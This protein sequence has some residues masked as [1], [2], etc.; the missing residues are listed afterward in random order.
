MKR[1]VLNM[2]VGVVAGCVAG[3]VAALL[4]TQSPEQAAT[5]RAVPVLPVVSVPVVS[6]RLTDL[7]EVLCV[8]TPELPVG[9]LW[10]CR[11]PDGMA[12]AEGE[13]LPAV[14]DGEPVSAKAVRTVLDEETG[15]PSL[16]LE[17]PRGLDST[18]SLE[19]TVVIADTEQA[20]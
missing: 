4:F 14:A 11:L 20:V 2:A 3:I 1:S 16:I 19:A 13:S 6:Q 5:E 7:V 10:Q 9:R 15:E 8:Q 18:A 12:V 17:V